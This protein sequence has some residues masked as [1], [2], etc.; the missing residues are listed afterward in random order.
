[1]TTCRKHDEAFYA[2]QGESLGSDLRWLVSLFEQPVIVT[3]GGYTD[4]QHRGCALRLSGAPR[5][6][7]V[8]G[9]ED[10]PLP[11]LNDWQY[12]GDG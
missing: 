12:E 3:G 5:A 6:V 11:R 2:G 4:G 1:M 7:V 9:S 8:T 10:V